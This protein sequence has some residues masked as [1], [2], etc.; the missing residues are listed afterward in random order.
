[1]NG[2]IRVASSGAVLATLSACAA[3]TGPPGIEPSFLIVGGGGLF[4]LGVLVGYWLCK[5]SKQRDEEEK[6]D[7]KDRY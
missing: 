5:R 7:K 3:S 1:M 4:A 6:K 2:K